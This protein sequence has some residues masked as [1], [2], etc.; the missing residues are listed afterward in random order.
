MCG[1]IEVMLQLVAFEKLSCS[2][3]IECRISKISYLSEYTACIILKLG[4][5]SVKVHVCFFENIFV[6]YLLFCE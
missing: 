4:L 3:K 6:V 5:I 2:I 1:L